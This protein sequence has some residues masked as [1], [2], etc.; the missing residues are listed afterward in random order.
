VKEQMADLYAARLAALGY[1]VLTFD[2]SGWGASGGD[3][4][5]IEIPHRKID[6]IVAATRFLRTFACIQEDLIGYVAICASAMYASAAI[7]L[8]APIRSLAC[9]AG[10]L[11]DAASVADFYGGAAGVA[12][13][14]RRAQE[15][16]RRVLDGKSD[17]LVPA[18]DE[19]NDRAGMF[20]H[21]DYYANP[22][23]GRIASWRN[24]MS[25]QTWVY[26]LTFNGLRAAEQLATPVLFVHGDDCALPD[27]VKRIYDRVRGPK[28]LLWHPGFQVDFYDRRDLVDLTVTEADQH[29]RGTLCG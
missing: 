3:A 19:G 21:M 24:E 26:W 16:L 14:I 17:S 13:R 6:D 4:R 5:Q 2:F 29:F 10:W 18:Y 8:G 15:A 1:T 12:M 7:E 20:I 22:A 27:N 28:K 23:R 11:H 25:E 9:I